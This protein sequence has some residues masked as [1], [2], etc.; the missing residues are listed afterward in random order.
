M[1]ELKVAAF[2]AD[3]RADEQARAVRLG[4]PRSIAVALHQR[5]ILVKHCRFHWHLSGHGFLDR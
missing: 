1:H 4:K 5:E 3:L 2:A